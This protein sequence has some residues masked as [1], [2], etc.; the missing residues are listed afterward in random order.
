MSN[1]IIEG[2]L[3]K[4]K[5]LPATIETILRL[6]GLNSSY[7]G[8][9][10]LIYGIELVIEKPDILTCICKGLYIE[11]ALHFN[12]TVYCVERNI[13]TA[14]EIIWESGNK[15]MLK[16]LFGDAYKETPPGNAA[17]IDML[18]YYIGSGIH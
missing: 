15:E 2:Y 11:I 13:R 12:T 9:S 3:N 6:L 1:N 5:S 7:K 8:Y 14:K 17:F 10:F 16:A 4:T 18:A